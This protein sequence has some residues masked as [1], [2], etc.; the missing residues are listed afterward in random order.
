MR[1]PWRSPIAQEDVTAVLTALFNIRA[2]LVD[3]RTILSEDDGEER[4]ES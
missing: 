2:E 1:W 3:I 4:E